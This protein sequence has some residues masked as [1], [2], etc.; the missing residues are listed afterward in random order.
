MTSSTTAGKQIINRMAQKEAENKMTLM[1]KV[2]EKILGGNL[3]LDELLAAEK[4]GLLSISK[5]HLTIQ[6]TYEPGDFTP[7]NLFRG[8]LLN[9][10]DQVPEAAAQR[11]FEMLKG[12]EG[13]GMDE[14]NLVHPPDSFGKE[15]LTSERKNQISKIKKD[16]P[17][18]G[19]IELRLRILNDHHRLTGNELKESEF[20]KSIYLVMNDQISEAIYYLGRNGWSASQ[21]YR[22][23]CSEHGSKRSDTQVREEV[24]RII[25]NF[26]GGPIGLVVSSITNLLASSS[27]SAKET[28]EHSLRELRRFIRKNCGEVGLEL[29][30][31]A[32]NRVPRQDV[33]A[34]GR[35]VR[36]TL[37]ET[38][39]EYADERRKKS[40]I[41]ELIPRLE[42]LE[43][44]QAQYPNRED[45]FLGSQVN[46]VIPV[47]TAP[48]APNNQPP[49][50]QQD[51]RCCFQCG[52]QGHISRD[53]PNKPKK[54]ASSKRTPKA[55]YPG[56]TF[57]QD[58]R[59]QHDSYASMPCWVHKGLPHKNKECRKQ[60][61]LPC[62]IPGH[63][64][65]PQALCMIGSSD[66]RIVHH[67]PTGM[68]DGYADPR[69]G[70][71]GFPQGQFSWQN[72]QQPRALNPPAWS[73]PQL[74]PPQIAYQPTTGQQPSQHHIQGSPSTT[75]QGL[76]TAPG[77][78]EEFTSS[79]RFA[80]ALGTFL[81][82]ISPQ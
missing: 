39:Q 56:K 45:S 9:L 2:G 4:S 60:Q 66:P 73:Q 61:N 15:E 11:A 79:E 81:R 44:A 48:V 29:T 8:A 49:V 64:N 30:E 70:Q 13:N 32:F 41:H 18:N 77:Q 76:P 17:A 57:N 74:Q 36:E 6:N 68:S 7:L 25:D 62:P 10:P 1:E 67:A 35:I 34:Y 59:N 12:A 16:I 54:P 42:M 78:P 19:S 72:S 33:F 27:S 26:R 24:N 46:Q 40:R 31:S 50:S 14:S 20:V 58:N 21:M 75:P 71:Q 53:C 51:P 69:R 65:H 5:D 43:A 47:M 63:G 82:A 23:L 52:T 3:P 80:T 55:V 37:G 28:M 38:L 22:Y